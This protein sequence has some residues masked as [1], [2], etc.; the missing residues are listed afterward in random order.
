L[1]L[2]QAATTPV[3]LSIRNAPDDVVARLKLRAARIRRSLQ[4]ERLAITTAAASEPE[5]LK[6]D[7]LGVPRVGLAAALQTGLMA[8][9]AMHRLVARAL[10]AEP[11]TR[12]RTLERAAEAQPK[13]RLRQ[14]R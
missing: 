1:R 12:D 13:G 11:V 5:P 4:G 10:S 9:D 6:L 14:G 2:P 7:A 3:T 8:C